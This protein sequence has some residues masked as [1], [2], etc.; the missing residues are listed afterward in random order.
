MYSNY[1]EGFIEMIRRIQPTAKVASGGREI[2]LRCR[3]CGDSDDIRKAHMYVKVPQSPDDISLYEC[4]KCKTSG[5]VNNDFLQMYDCNDPEIFMTISKQVNDHMHSSKY[6]AIRIQK[7]YNLDNTLVRDIEKIQTKIDYINTR[8]GVSLSIEDWLQLKVCFNLDNLL[9]KNRLEASREP[10]VVSMLRD[11]FVG[12]ISYD[13]TCVIE[14]KYDDLELPDF[15]NRKYI[16]YKLFPNMDHGKSYYTIPT[17][18]DLLNPLPVDIHI[19]EGVFDILG[20]YLNLNKCSNKQNIYISANGKSY[21]QALKF[22]LTDLGIINFN[23]HL[24]PDMDVSD[25]EFNKLVLKKIK[26][27]I[28]PT[29]KVYIHRNT[30]PGEKDYGVP[31]E[32]IHDTKVGVLI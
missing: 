19:A 5:I 4:K 27:L 6:T 20:I 21:L 12:F 7:R 3:Y 18:I 1:G 31:M 28:S 16:V 2:V 24:Y 32:R 13:N 29:C 15:I 23:I 26:G 8:L 25:R 10:Y 14:R 9:L 22:I 11:H 30:Y 17:Q